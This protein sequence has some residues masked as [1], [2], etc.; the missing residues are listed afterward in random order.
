[1]LS[2]C[3]LSFIQAKPVSLELAAS[4]AAD[5]MKTSVK[6]MEY[7]SES[8][9]LFTGKGGGFVLVS[10]DDGAV[11]ILAFSARGTVG[12][13]PSFRAWLDNYEKYLS[14]ELSK[15][16][17]RHSLWD[18][19]EEISLSKMVSDSVQALVRTTWNQTNPYND[20][21]PDVPESWTPGSGSDS[22][23]FV[24]CVAVVMGQIMNYYEYPESGAGRYFYA[25][26][27]TGYQGR[28]Y[29][30]YSYDWGSIASNIFGGSTSAEVNDVTE[31]LYHCAVSVG[32][33]YGEDG[34]SS[35]VEDAIYA[36]VSHFDYDR[37]FTIAYS[38]NYDGGDWTALLKADLDA[39]RP[40]IYRGSGSG[41]HAFICDGYK[42]VNDQSY[43]HFNWGW[44]G[45]YDGW[46]LLNDLTPGDN[47][48]SEN[49]AAI[50]GIHPSDSLDITLGFQGFERISYR[51][52][53]LDN[54]A[55]YTENGSLDLVREKEY[56]AGFSN[57]SQRVVTPQ[58][59]VPN[60]NQAH[61]SF[62]A[63]TLNGKICRIAVST[64]DTERA[65]FVNELDILQPANGLWQYYDY[66]LRNYKQQNI[67]LA[68]EYASDTTY[69]FVDDLRVHASRNS[70]SL[71]ASVP[72]SSDL[73]K[74]YPN[75]VN[76]ELSVYFSIEQAGH[77]ELNLYGLD[78]RR[79]ENFY[80]ENLQIGKYRLQQIPMDHPSGAYILALELDN[81]IISSRKIS[82][83]K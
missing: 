4:L 24:G 79:V 78:G 13:N 57:T 18:R 12:D 20:A 26:P 83:L 72:E 1:M 38:E 41:G 48:F 42:V 37:N 76:G 59:H 53:I 16:H 3:I 50:L 6:N 2:L 63:K 22:K 56:S 66:S 15:P 77:A 43:F 46:F 62:W 81:K 23:V 11:P 74:S 47:D 5:V 21:F 54:Q 73:L 28:D 60:D 31:L 9:Y 61:V 45:Y 40:I 64:T 32:M 14:V 71:E 29:Y 68:L 30:N 52:W 10:A 39:G 75:P 70:V 65:S 58:I 19:M 35:A 17:S 51:G 44:G 49:Q 25:D 80:S 34:S 67:Y 33:L 36:L 69:F 27:A 8:T 55:F 7:H 82:L